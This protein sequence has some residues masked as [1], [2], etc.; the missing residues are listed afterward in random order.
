MSDPNLEK[1]NGKVNE[2]DPTIYN[3]TISINSLSDRAKY[4]IQSIRKNFATPNQLEDYVY[5]YFRPLEEGREESSLKPE[6]QKDVLNIER[7]LVTDLRHFT[8]KGLQY[9]MGKKQ[10]TFANF[11]MFKGSKINLQRLC[12]ELESNPKLIHK[13]NSIFEAD[14]ETSR[15]TFMAIK[16][17]WVF[18]ELLKRKFKREVGH[19][20]FKNVDKL[21]QDKVVT[22]VDKLKSKAKTIDPN[23]FTTSDYRDCLSIQDIEHYME[24]RSSAS[25][26]KRHH[27]S[28]ESKKS[29][30]AT[31]K[32]RLM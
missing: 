29:G 16:C 21:F 7:L 15:T 12:D 5:Y 20:T 4:K 28:K 23:D 11:E 17:I 14:S 13:K 26:E 2:K 6:F 22:L 18:Y 24:I 19:M 31:K 9:Y 8:L 3:K 1:D 25:T 10:D 32:R 30:G 27:S